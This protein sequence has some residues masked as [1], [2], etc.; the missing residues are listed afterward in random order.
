MGTLGIFSRIMCVTKGS[1]M[2][3]ASLDEETAAG[4]INIHKMRDLYNLVL[5]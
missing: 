2:T 1:F 4:Q 3:Y 5:H